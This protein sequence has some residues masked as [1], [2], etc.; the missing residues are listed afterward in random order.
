[1]LE[2]TLLPPNLTKYFP[3]RGVTAMP[4]IHPLDVS[5]KTSVY[6]VILQSYELLL[7]LQHVYNN[8]HR[9]ELVYEE[10]AQAMERFRLQHGKQDNGL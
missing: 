3:T 2:M 10:V 4:T 6:T 9:L 7:T 8:E 1:M 5:V